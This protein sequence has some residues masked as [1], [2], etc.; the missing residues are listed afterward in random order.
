MKTIYFIRHGQSEGNASL[1]TQQGAHTLLTERGR[2]QAAEVARDIKR[3]PIEALIAS[4]FVRAKATAEAVS[5]EIK[6]P[7]AFSELFVERRRPGVQLKKRK[8]H[9]HWIWTQLL[10]TLFSRFNWYRHS[11][12]E[13][14]ADLIARAHEALA[15]IS[16]R[17]ETQI[18]VVT[19][20][21]FMRA[22]HAVMTLGEGVSARAYLRA[23][24]RMRMRNTA[25]MIATF[26][27]KGWKVTAW[28]EDAAKLTP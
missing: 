25:L 5:A 21:Q 1:R 16:A 9:P 13:T 11:D 10:L 23:T 24:R 17:S 28:N 12:E 19:H 22:L 2:A 4:P 15:F 14:P 20:G 8:N 27:K 3:L 18:V 26:D 6:L 7:I